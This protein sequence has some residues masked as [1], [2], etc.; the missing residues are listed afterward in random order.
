M[1][2]E[3]LTRVLQQWRYS[4][5][6]ASIFA[7]SLGA[8]NRV[9]ALGSPAN[10]YLREYRTDDLKKIQTEHDLLCS[11]SNHVDAIIPPLQTEKGKSFVQMYGKAY[12]LFPAAKGR[13]VS[14][15]DLTVSHAFCAGEMLATLHKLLAEFDSGRFVTVE[16]KWD[17]S[18]WLTRLDLVIDEIR[19][20]GSE[21]EWVLQRA[22]QQRKYLAQSNDHHYIPTTQRSL[23][24]GDYHHFNLF[25][26]EQDNVS[27][28]IDWDLLQ[29][30]PPAYEVARACAYM[31]QLDVSKSTAFIRGYQTQKPLSQEALSDGVKAWGM[32]ADHHVW[33][34]EEVYL[35][36]NLSAK[37]FIPRQKFTPFAQL[38]APIERELMR[39]S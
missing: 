20:A 16:L 34:L 8:T 27:G 12:A 19:K 1:E 17:K 9:F 22:N 38:W 33:A 28:V 24:H 37:K 7:E 10:Y 39:V 23:I 14:Q 29:Y 4:V 13:L 6:P 25:F 2:S 18:E 35:K 15:S 30:M 5:E 31:F 3:R 11:L 32:F 21:D 26:D 36:A